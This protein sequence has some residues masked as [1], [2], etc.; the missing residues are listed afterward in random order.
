MCVRSG[1]TFFSGNPGTSGMDRGYWLIY[2]NAA[3]VNLA[4]GLPDAPGVWRF[5]HA[6]N[7]GLGSTSQTT[8]L[9]SATNAAVGLPASGGLWTTFR[10]SVNRNAGGSN[11]LL[12]AINGTEIYRGP[13]PA[14]GPYSGPFAVGFRENHPGDPEAMEGTWVDNL[15]FLGTPVPVVITEFGVDE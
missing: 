5:V 4:D 8:V 14:N 1:S 7:D 9:G 11:Q 15:Q 10:L 13:L 3:G 12:A 2:E 6:T